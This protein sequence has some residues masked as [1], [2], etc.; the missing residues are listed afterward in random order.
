MSIYLYWLDEVSG[1]M[2]G[3]VENPE[4]ILK[5][6]DSSRTDLICIFAPCH[7]NDCIDQRVKVCYIPTQ[8]CCM[9]GSSEF[10]RG[11][12]WIFSL[13]IAARSDKVIVPRN[14]RLLDELD[15]WAIQFHNVI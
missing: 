12:S 3:V 13:E 8:S 10:W 7:N 9:L 4:A 14:F 2:R 6:R 15:A 11:H 5:G 1:G